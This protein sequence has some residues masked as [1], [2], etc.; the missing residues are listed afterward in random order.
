M[1]PSEPLL[2][3]DDVANFLKIDVVTVRRL[4]SRN[5][6]GAYRIGNEFRFS[7]SD[8]RAYLERQHIPAQPGTSLVF[9]ASEMIGARQEQGF[10][11]RM[12]FQLR[13]GKP[14]KAAPARARGGLLDSFT[15]RAKQALSVAQEEARRFNHP[16]VGTEHLLLALVRDQN[17]IAGHVLS[18]RGISLEPAREAVSKI[19]GRGEAGSV[20][21][22]LELTASA[23]KILE[24]ALDESN[25]LGQQ[26]V[27]NEHLLLGLVR[28]GEGVAAGVLEALGAD[29]QSLRDD[30]LAMVRDKAGTGTAS[31]PV[32]ATGATQTEAELGFLERLTG[33]RKPKA[34]LLDKLT[35]RA[36]SALNAS[37]QEARG[38]EKAYIGT[39]HVLLGLLRVQEGAA[40]KA[41]GALGV[42][43]E[44][45]RDAAASIA[46]GEAV[47]RPFPPNETPMTASTQRMIEGAFDEA[48]QL[49]S[50]YVGTKH[51]LLGLLR[52]ENS[53]GY[54]VLTW[55]R[56]D[57]QRL[58]AALLEPPAGERPPG[59]PD[60]DR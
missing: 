34:G 33:K 19:V 55:L 27:G 12:M 14:S 13:S 32:Q 40:A 52:L 25:E 46:E 18:K 45:A 22:D 36:K 47:E 38:L 29:L 60:N 21:G 35:R 49:G 23:R 28:K 9:A 31:A 44:R 39:E 41:L 53:V 48:K 17:S 8:V 10:L 51:L 37:V 4:V 20:Q 58:R 5:E 7:M 2:T 1:D 15:K 11:N 43:Y 56:V 57:I 24:Y 50:A 54:G 6:I 30:V 3:T 26:Y 16:Y 59:A 42:S